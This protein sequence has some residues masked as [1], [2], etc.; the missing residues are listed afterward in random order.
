MNSHTA[1]ARKMKM[2]RKNVL[3]LGNVFMLLQHV[4]GTSESWQEELVKEPSK[5]KE[6]AAGF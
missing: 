1:T 4:L 5:S 6:R 3:I 2:K